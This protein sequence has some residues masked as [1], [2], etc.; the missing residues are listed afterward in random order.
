MIEPGPDAILIG[1]ESSGIIRDAFRARGFNAWSCDLRA[2]EGDPRWHLHCDVFDIIDRGWLLGIFHPDCTYLTNSAAWALNDPDFERYPGVGYH[3]RPDPATLVGAARRDAKAKAL[4]TV[5]RIISAPI[6]LKA[7]ENPRGAIGTGIRKADQVIHPPQFGEDAA[8]ETH[9]WLWML[10]KLRPTGWRHGRIVEDDP[11][12]LFGGG[13]ERWANQ[14]DS[15]NN[16]VPESAERWIERS[17]TYS[18]IANAMAQQ[19]G[20][21]LIAH[22]GVRI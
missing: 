20:D 12:H 22:H 11:Q 4:R 9:L 7:I 8:K 17:R 15:G 16:R 14:S 5:E 18:G 10:P 21:W 1:M 6:P 13:V 3:Q 19:W 2:C